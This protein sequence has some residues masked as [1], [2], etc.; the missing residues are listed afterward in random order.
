MLGLGA[1]ITWGNHFR[2]YTQQVAISLL[3]IN[4]LCIYFLQLFWWVGV[5]FDLGSFILVGNGSALQYALE[6][7]NAASC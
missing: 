3:V 5:E 1:I 4:I 6:H 2:H 7:C